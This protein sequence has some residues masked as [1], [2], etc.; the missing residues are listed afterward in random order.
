MRGQDI[1][2]DELAKSHA[3]YLVGGKQDVPHERIF[4]FG[5]WDAFSWIIMLFN[6]GSQSFQKGLARYAHSYQ[7][8]ILLSTGIYPYFITVIMV[9]VG[10]MLTGCQKLIFCRSRKSARRYPGSSQ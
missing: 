6:V 9:Q 1:S 10:L 7:A 5:T 8:Y 2:N 3:R 4:R